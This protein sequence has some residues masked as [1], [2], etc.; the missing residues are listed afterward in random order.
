M[1]KLK[2]PTTKQRLVAEEIIRQKMAG[3]NVNKKKALAVAGYSPN[4]PSTTITNAPGFKQYFEQ[5]DLTESKFAEYLAE[6]LA[7]KPQNRL[8]ELQLLAKVLGLDKQTVDMNV[9]RV[10]ESL[11]LIKDIIAKTYE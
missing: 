6:D 4:T 11:D 9:N 3:E 10:D 7:N 5:F 1:P 8:G 2:E